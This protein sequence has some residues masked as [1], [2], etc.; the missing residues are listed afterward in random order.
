MH[1]QSQMTKS[2]Y[3]ARN[4][5]YTVPRAAPFAGK[6]LALAPDVTQGLRLSPGLCGPGWCVAHFTHRTVTR[7][8]AQA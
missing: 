1:T 6:T 5:G 8:I 7:R 4:T 3:A 2:H